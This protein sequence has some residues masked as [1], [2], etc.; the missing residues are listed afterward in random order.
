MNEEENGAHNKSG[1]I[2]EFVFILSCAVG[3]L[4]NVLTLRIQLE[5]PYSSHA[6]ICFVFTLFFVFLAVFSRCRM[7]EKTGVRCD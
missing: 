7:F 4:S 5:Y 2:W 1:A 3:L 6:Q